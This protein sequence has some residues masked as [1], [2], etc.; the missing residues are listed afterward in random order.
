ME[1]SSAFLLAV[2]VTYESIDHFYATATP[3]A[4]YKSDV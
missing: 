3:T 1:L 4:A 2:K